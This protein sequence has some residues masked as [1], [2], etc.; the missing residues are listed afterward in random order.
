MLQLLLTQIQ[1]IKAKGLDEVSSNA[2]LRSD[3]NAAY[4]TVFGKA[5]NNCSSCPLEE[6]FAKLIALDTEDKL[7]A[8]IN[9]KFLL[10]QNV[11]LTI[12][13]DDYTNENL[14]DDKAAEIL[15]QYPAFAAQF[16]RMP[17][18]VESASNDDDQEDGD[19][20]DVKVL[21]PDG[22]KRTRKITVGDLAQV[23]GEP[24]ND[25]DYRI[26]ET[27]FRVEAGFVVE[28]L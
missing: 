17:E 25:G 28:L 1:I 27:S 23:D 4:L 11:L 8:V 12:G 18:P 13:P 21:L 20:P 24:A 26:K 9:R 15:A 14:T 3:F 6:Q 7:D 19:A 2:E 5:A 10:K 16:E 22:R